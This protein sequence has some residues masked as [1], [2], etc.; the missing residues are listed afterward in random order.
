[1]NTA[2]RQ[3]LS[4]ENLPST[5]PSSDVEHCDACGAPIIAEPHLICAR[6]GGV[7][8]LRCFVYPYGSDQYRAECVDLD[9]AAEGGTQEEAIAG[10]Q[11]AMFGYLSVA[12]ESED[13]KGLLPRK[14]PLSHRLHYHLAR[15]K[16]RIFDIF[17]HDRRGCTAEKFYAI[18]SNVRC[19]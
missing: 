10:L 13:R 4:S 7:I 3:V 9:I 15:I 11:D 16:D 12:F 18:P 19:C 5:S 17:S 6:C 1:M 2:E 8:R 14:S